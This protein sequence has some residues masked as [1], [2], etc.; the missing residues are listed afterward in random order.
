MDGIIVVLG[1]LI[2]HLYA[3]K[4]GTKLPGEILSQEDYVNTA[5]TGDVDMSSRVSKLNENFYED[6]DAFMHVA[7]ALGF[8]KER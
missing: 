6:Q 5:A 3:V 2:L 8:P 7:H 1:L 4:S